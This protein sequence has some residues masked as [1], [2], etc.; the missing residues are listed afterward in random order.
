MFIHALALLFRWPILHGPGGGVLMWSDYELMPG[1][2]MMAGHLVRANGDATRFAEQYGLCP[3]CG[4]EI[5]L[6]E[7]VAGWRDFEFKGGE[8]GAPPGETIH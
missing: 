5:S 3:E 8:V 2:I 6:D 4:R 1:D 7:A